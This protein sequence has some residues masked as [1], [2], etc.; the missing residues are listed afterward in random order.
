[1]EK[2]NIIVFGT[3]GIGGFFGS[4][5][6]NS[7]K[8]KVHITFVARG[9]HLK[10]I[11]KNGLMLS[12]YDGEYKTCHPDFATDNIKE[13][14]LPDIILLAVKSYD[15]DVALS[16]I[17]EVIRKD[18]I[19]LPLMNG[20]D[21]YKRIRKKIRGGIVIPSCVYMTSFIEKPGLI[22]H[23]PGNGLLFLGEDPVNKGFFPEIIH[24]SLNVPGI[25]CNFVD[26]IE[27]A[28]WEKFI[29]IAPYSLVTAY[30]NKSIG[31]VFSDYILKD[32]TRQI[33]IE[34]YDLGKA[35]GIHFDDY[36]V[37]NA[38][39]RARLLPN[40]AKTSFQRDIENKGIKNESDIFARTIISIAEELKIL[41]PVTR[42]VY[43]KLQELISSKMEVVAEV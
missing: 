7:K 21:I 35:K 37:E 3:G 31:D 16:Q 6:S 39:N 27:I 15:L 40:S 36:V 19:I 33:M 38:I 32:L 42:S 8:E 23:R 2:S 17:S 28:I 12:C 10:A 30:S 25:N 22:V 9:E 34:I 41:I 24:D 43:A 11:K 20:I 13:A 4:Q 18:T 26:D 29:F 1:M 14:P 5:I